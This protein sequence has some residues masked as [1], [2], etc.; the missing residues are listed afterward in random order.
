M[1]VVNDNPQQI[2]HSKENELFKVYQ[3]TFLI[4][5][6]D[7]TAT[8]GYKPEQIL[9]E[10]EAAFSHIAVAKTSRD[11]N[12]SDLNYHKAL[13]HIQRAILDASKILWL[14]YK[15]E[16]DL[17]FNDV[18]SR[19][20]YVNE[21]E[22]E[23]VKLYKEAE[24]LASEARQIEIANVGKDPLSSINKFYEATI[25]LKNV[26]SKIDWDKFNSYKQ[27]KIGYFVKNQLWG[28]IIGVVA[29]IIANYIFTQ[30][31]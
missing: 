30:L 4:I 11:T 19:K 23:F 13:G 16:I 24:K 3:D 17:V 14:H 9:I 31:F 21:T 7:L 15:K 18:K 28:F 12:E 26:Y 22:S 6:A 5:Y 8:I 2:P 25:A 27:F 1:N 10:I 29:G 20:F